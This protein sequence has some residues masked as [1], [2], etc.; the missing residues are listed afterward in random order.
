MKKIVFIIICF[1]SYSAL[2]ASTTYSAGADGF[3]SVPA[4]TTPYSKKVTAGFHYTGFD[5]HTLTPAFNFTPVSKEKFG[6]EFGAAWDILPD[7]SPAL[8]PILS[9]VK[10]RFSKSA[11]LGGWF[12]IP[13]HNSQGLAFNL[14]FAWQVNFKLGRMGSGSTSLGIGYTFQSALR[15]DIN[16]HIGF[17]QQAFIPELFL[18]ADFANYPYRHS[19]PGMLNQSVQRGI[20]NIGLRAV[21][22]SFLSLDLAGVDLMDQTRGLR[23]SLNL[24]F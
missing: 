5:S 18:V 8:A 9:G 7:N 6:L 12:E 16:F 21:L 19:G 1:V 14:Y 13:V 4:V 2:F 24:Y 20:V 17:M 11:A 3:I 22:V 10:L 23:G 15:R